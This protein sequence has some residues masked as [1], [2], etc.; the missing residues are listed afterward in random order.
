MSVSKLQAVLGTAAL[1][2]FVAT[3]SYAQQRAAAAG[4]AYD[5]ETRGPVPIPPSERGLQTV[6]A[7]PWFK[8]SRESMVLEG[9]AFERDGNLLFCD[10]SGRR[11]MRLT[12]DKRLS[13]VIRL[14]DVS[15]GDLDRTTGWCYVSP[16][17]KAIMPVLP[18]LAMANGIALSPN[19][20]ELWVT[21]FARNLLHRIEL[22]GQQT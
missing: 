8:V 20:T 7:E 6:I 13:T 12:P 9:A 19:G 18:H 3:G 10:V 2:A 22:A 16:D 11:V 14:D 4:L 15:P 17:F 5:P 21:E 1:F